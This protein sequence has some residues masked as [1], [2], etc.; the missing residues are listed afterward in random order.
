MEPELAGLYSHST[1]AFA[2]LNGQCTFVFQ[3]PVS[4]TLY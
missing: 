3:A 4:M 2:V 1:F